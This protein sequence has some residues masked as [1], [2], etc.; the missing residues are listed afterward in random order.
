MPSN[1]WHDKAVRV[2]V[3]VGHPAII[4]LVPV[5][6]KG[7]PVNSRVLYIDDSSRV[8]AVATHILREASIEVA[9]ADGNDEALD[10]LAKR[11]GVFDV[12]IQDCQR[13]LGRCLTD[14]GPAEGLNDL[15]GLFFLRRHVW[16]LNPRMP[17]IMV[18]MDPLFVLFRRDPAL[19]GNPLFHYLPKPSLAK[20]LVQAVY[21]ATNRT[22][23]GIE[24]VGRG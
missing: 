6:M 15:S 5:F 22:D 20:G 17:C 21:Y 11:P 4:Y 12:V 16:R 23:M 7:R 10:L 2:R 19:V 3:G 18:T 14:L 1:G 9:T 13:P 24:F 8:L